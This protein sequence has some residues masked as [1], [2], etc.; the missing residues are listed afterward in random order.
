MRLLANW[1]LSRAIRSN[2]WA[3]WAPRLTW[4]R[5]LRKI[6]ISFNDSEEL[7]YPENKGIYYKYF[8]VI[9]KVSWTIP[10]NPFWDNG[11][12][13]TNL[14][15][16]PNANLRVELQAQY[17]F[18]RPCWWCGLKTKM[19]PLYSIL[20][21][22]L[23]VLTIL[24]NISQWEGLSHILWKIKNVW[25][26]Q[27]DRIDRIGKIRSYWNRTMKPEVF[28]NGGT[29]QSSSIYIGLSMKYP[30]GVPPCMETSNSIPMSRTIEPLTSA[31]AWSP[32]RFRDGGVD[33]SSRNN[34]RPAPWSGAAWQRVESLSGI[35]ERYP[36]KS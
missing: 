26:H 22:W 34:R 14:W 18:C 32:R 33:W 12:I 2:T 27:P 10:S 30:A 6:S 5:S 13:D 11:I 7:A 3:M 17:P 31:R 19:P 16:F 20:D 9:L 36:L 23:V 35:W 15:H 24:K 8:T 29:P 21:S 4:L 25:N 1:G 28:W